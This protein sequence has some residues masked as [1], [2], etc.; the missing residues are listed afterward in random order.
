MNSAQCFK[1]KKS[2]NI[3]SY[4]EAKMTNIDASILSLP[5]NV[6]EWTL[7]YL[8]PLYL[9]DNHKRIKMFSFVLECSTHLDLTLHTALL[10]AIEFSVPKR[11]IH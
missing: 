6:I 10:G 11:K 8:R 5:E 7:C 9:Y 2:G 3:L 1:K 4:I